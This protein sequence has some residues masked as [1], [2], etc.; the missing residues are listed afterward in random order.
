MFERKITEE[1]I[2]EVIESGFEKQNIIISENAIFTLTFLDSEIL[3]RLVLY[4]A[5]QDIPCPPPSYDEKFTNEFHLRTIHHKS[6]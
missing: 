1:D 3:K 4:F 5:R 6:S 2:F